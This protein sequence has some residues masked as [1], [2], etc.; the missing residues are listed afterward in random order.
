MKQRPQL[1]YTLG[2]QLYLEIHHDSADER[3]LGKVKKN[4]KNEKEWRDL[5][6][7][8]VFYSRENPFPQESLH[9][10]TLIG[11]EMVGSGFHPNGYYGRTDSHV[12]RE[13]VDKAH[14]VYQERFFVLRNGLMPAVIVECG[15]IANPFEESHL[16]DP[17]TKLKIAESI[18]RAV[19][20][21]VSQK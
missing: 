8:S 16:K 2:G 5:S 13:V 9:L 6:G 17:Q 19:S 7:F 20:R 21:Y 15:V 4:S 18:D 11:E 3:D 14:G 10:A 1:A 12:R